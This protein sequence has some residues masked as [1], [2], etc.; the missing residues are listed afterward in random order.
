MH[1]CYSC[2]AI[3][4]ANEADGGSARFPAR[5]AGPPGSANGGIAVGALACP[6][7]AMA[8]RAGAA[9]AAVTRISARIRAGVPLETPLAAAAEASDGA[10]SVAISDG[11]AALVTGAVEIAR[12]DAPQQPGDVLAPVS[13]DRADDIT[14]LSTVDVPDRPPFFEETGEHPIRG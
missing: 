3:F 6:A 10:Y 9:H 13:N 5:F 8:S 14:Q 4:G 11:D 1:R 7:L 2:R 12:F